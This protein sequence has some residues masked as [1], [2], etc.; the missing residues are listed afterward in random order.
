V[1]L[2]LVVPALS[3][4]PL[5]LVC[6]TVP[7]ECGAA[8][9]RP[10]GGI[11]AMKS[12]TSQDG[13]VA[14]RE[15]AAPLL[16][17]LIGGHPEESDRYT[18]KLRS[19]GYSVV[20]ATGL[21]QGL[22]RARAVQPDLIFVCLGMWALPGLVLMVLRSD[23]VAGGVPTVLVSDRPRAQ[24]AAEVGGL[25]ATENVAPLNAAVHAARVERALSGPATSCA[26]RPGWSQWRAVRNDP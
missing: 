1:V 23:S 17:L 8:A 24:L 10:T 9:P 7:V 16:A 13:E 19:D 2:W 3:N 25:L 26:R 18:A 4:D 20:P 12:S 5:R 14:V 22:E 11:S 15:T 6:S 21:E